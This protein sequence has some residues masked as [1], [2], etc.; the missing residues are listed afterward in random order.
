VTAVLAAGVE[1]NARYVHRA[2]GVLQA[3]HLPAG[4]WSVK[5]RPV[6]DR[7]IGFAVPLDGNSGAPFVLASGPEAD[8]FVTA[9]RWADSARTLG[10]RYDRVVFAGYGSALDEQPVDVAALAVTA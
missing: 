9:M 8:V 2:G 5:I 1:V 4:C 10:M 6:G 7:W 3:I